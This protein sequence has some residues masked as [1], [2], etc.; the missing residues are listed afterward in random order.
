M[1]SVPESG[2]EPEERNKLFGNRMLPLQITEIS[3]S[4]SKGNESR[5]AVFF[6]NQLLSVV[7]LVG[8]RFRGVE[9]I[10]GH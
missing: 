5:K 4:K 7:G 6:S 8:F 10:V 2:F 3:M 1:I 9:V